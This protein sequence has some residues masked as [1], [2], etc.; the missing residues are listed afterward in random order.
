MKLIFDKKT[1]RC[2]GY[3]SYC[4][5]G[6]EGLLLNINQDDIVIK[7]IDI[8]ITELLQKYKAE[9]FHDLIL[10]KLGKIKKRKFKK[11]ISEETQNNQDNL[12]DKKRNNMLDFIFDS[13]NNLEDRFNA[14]I[15]LLFQRYSNTKDE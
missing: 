8:N 14:L 4:E 10:T 2:L 3:I 15:S 13:N 12:I 1:R 7:E 5:D 11:Q 9:T 6:K